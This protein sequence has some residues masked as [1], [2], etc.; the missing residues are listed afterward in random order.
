MIYILIILICIV[1]IILCTFFIYNLYK[2]NEQLEK[3]IKD[4]EKK[5]VKMYEDAQKYYI[6]F[7]RLFSEAKSQLDRVDKK[8]AFSSDDEVGFSFKVIKTAIDNVVEQLETI[9]PETEN[10]ESENKK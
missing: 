2:Q 8:G 1:I 9:K 3:F 7:L 4:I 5:E 6:A 10:D